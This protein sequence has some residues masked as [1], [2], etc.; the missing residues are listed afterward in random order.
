MDKEEQDI[1][2]VADM[3]TV[4]P[5]ALAGVAKSEFRYGAEAFEEYQKIHAEKV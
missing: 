2:R 5:A 1:E 4:S 3:E